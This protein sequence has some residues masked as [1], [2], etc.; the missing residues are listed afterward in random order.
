MPHPISPVHADR[1]ADR[2][3]VQS[4]SEPLPSLPQASERSTGGPGVSFPPAQCGQLVHHLPRPPTPGAARCA[5]HITQSQPSP[6]HGAMREGNTSNRLESRTHSPARA[7][8]GCRDFAL[9]PSTTN[10]QCRK[11]LPPPPPPPARLFC[12][13][14]PPS[15]PRSALGPEELSNNRLHSRRG[16]LGRAERRRRASTSRAPFAKAR[17]TRRFLRRPGRVSL[18]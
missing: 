17:H 18:L 4:R 7:R 3:L 8:R 2:L 11:S 15:P 16:S 6:I 1:L 12:L 9:Q 13:P 10:T 14:V 5:C